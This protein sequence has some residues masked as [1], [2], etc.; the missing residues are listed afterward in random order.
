MSYYE[1]TLA[2]FDGST[3][4]TDDLIKWVKAPNIG[5]VRKHYPYAKVEELGF[6]PPRQDVDKV[7]R[8]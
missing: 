8:K 6:V 2:G 4:E 1:V 7:L 3:D 5:V